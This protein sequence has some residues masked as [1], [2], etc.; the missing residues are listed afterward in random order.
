[1]QTSVAAGV[2]RRR[3]AVV[4]ALAAGLMAV[5]VAPANAGAQTR[6]ARSASSTRPSAGSAAS[7][8]SSA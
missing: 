4:G 2:G 7:G 8:R 3:T 6:E 5:A 1:M